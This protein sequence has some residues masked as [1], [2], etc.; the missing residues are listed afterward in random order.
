MNARI[1]A[2][3]LALGFFFAPWAAQAAEAR[4]VLTVHHA[5]CVLCPAIIKGALQHVQGVSAVTVGE[6]DAQADV[7][8]QVTYD[9]AQASPGALIK[10]TTDQ[11]YPADISKK[12][13]G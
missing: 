8:A 1:A 6:A 4:A 11:G 10:A 2:T 7:I 13:G 3:T 9:D 12:A 5:S